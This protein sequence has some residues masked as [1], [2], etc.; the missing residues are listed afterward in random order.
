MTTGIPLDAP[1]VICPICSKRLTRRRV[2]K[3]R[4]YDN[5]LCDICRRKKNGK[6]EQSGKALVSV[7]ARTSNLTR[8]NLNHCSQCGW[9]GYCEVHHK[10]RNR[11]HNTLDNL[12][13]LCPNCHT[14]KHFGKPKI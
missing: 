11:T 6:P 1:R 5:S 10:D 7:F 12:D 4:V 3:N 14:D 2:I 13:V 8:E 9:F